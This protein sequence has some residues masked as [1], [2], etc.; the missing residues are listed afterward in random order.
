MKIL[1]KIDKGT[2]KSVN[3]KIKTN[4][5]HKKHKVINILIIS[6][7]YKLIKMQIYKCKIY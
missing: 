6:K 5:L 4:K 2:Q 3:L 7:N 1:F